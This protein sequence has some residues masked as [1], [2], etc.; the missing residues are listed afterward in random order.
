MGIALLGLGA[1]AVFTTENSSGAAALIAVGAVLL[2][3]SLFTD[4]IE[5]VEA[6]GMKLGLRRQAQSKLIE[7]ELAESRG[8]TAAAHELREQAEGILAAADKISRGFE[9]LRSGLPSGWARTDRLEQQMREARELAASMDWRPEQVQQ[10]FTS[11]SDGNR[12][13]AL[14]IMQGNARLADFEL[15]REALINSR[16]AF[17]QYQALKAARDALRLSQVQLTPAEQ[18]FVDAARTY[19][20]KAH[21]S[22]EQGDRVQLAREISALTPRA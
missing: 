18:L 15:L 11:G 20:E 22:R 17:E 12:L 8:D 7:A 6:L 5:S 2:G 14:A 4:R 13:T 1:Y 9:S 19:S 21:A 10:M 3:V 16:S